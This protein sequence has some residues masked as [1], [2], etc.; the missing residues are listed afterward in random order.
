MLL[1]LV[2][3]SWL[4]NNLCLFGRLLYGL[5]LCNGFNIVYKRRFKSLKNFS[6]VIEWVFF[7]I[8]CSFLLGILLGDCL[9]FVGICK[10]I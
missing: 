10:L 4:F 1:L 6:N 2:Y 9:I 5:N 8:I 7:I 3:V